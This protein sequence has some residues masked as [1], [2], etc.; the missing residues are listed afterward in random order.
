M[1]LIGD[2]EAHR[3]PPLLAIGLAYMAEAG[4]ISSDLQ[5]L[6]PIRVSNE[7]RIIDSMS[8]SL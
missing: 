7:N 3:R 5:I 6:H 8:V 4:A 1:S 2:S